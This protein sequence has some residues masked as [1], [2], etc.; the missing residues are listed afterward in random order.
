MSVI[1]WFS[2]A[3]MSWAWRI[4]INSIYSQS[5]MLVTFLK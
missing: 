2:V 3:N 1:D 4:L 5:V